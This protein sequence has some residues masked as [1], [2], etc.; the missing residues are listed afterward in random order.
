MDTREK[1]TE[2]LLDFTMEEILTADDLP[3]EEALEYLVEY[4]ALTLRRPTVD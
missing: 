2:L 3:V 1:I 4:G